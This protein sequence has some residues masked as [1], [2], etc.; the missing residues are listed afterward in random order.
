MLI[1]YVLILSEDSPVKFSLDELTF[2]STAISTLPTNTTLVSDDAHKDDRNHYNADG[3]VRLAGLNDLEV[4]LLGT[5]G[6]LRNEDKIKIN[7][8]HHKGSFG[9]LAMLKTL[10]DTYKYGT[11]EDFSKVKILYIHA[12]GKSSASKC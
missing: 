4:S 11:V 9:A 12:A 5:S 1:F 7:F 3:I 8:D 6:E 2:V 10:A